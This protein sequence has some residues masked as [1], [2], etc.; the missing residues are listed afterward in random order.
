MKQLSFIIC[1]IILQGINSCFAQDSTAFKPSGKIIARSFI[2]YSTGF[3][4]VNHEKGFD[5]TRAFLGYN[6]KFTRTFSGQVIIDGASGKSSSN[7]IEVHLRNAFVNWSDK[8]FNI[9]VGLTGLMQF[10]IQENYFMHRYVLKSFQDLNKMAPS[11]DLGV[12]AE[13][14]FND[15]ISADVSITNGEGYK[16]IKKDNNMRYAAGISLHPIKNTILRVYADIYNDDE[17]G[18]DALPESATDAKYKDQY[19]LSL[20]A[21]YQD[22]NISGGV[23][24]NR[25]Y[26]KGFIEKKDYYGYSAYASGKVASKWRVFARYDLMDS[27][28]PD[29]FTSPW[30]SLDGQLMMI[31]VEFQP[32]KQLKIAPNFRNI[33]ADRS[34]SE[35]YAYIN[36]EFNL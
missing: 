36:I 24:Y 18:R 14:K 10:S 5:I 25:V 29:N 22:K 12:T 6:Y 1:I 7:D 31:G 16:K 8:G 13:Y 30:N 28:N 33:N 27:T 9:N 35:Q 32:L 11:V 3:G 26:N 23:E 4:H 15:Y 21:G 2:D 34:K 19:S 20:F 17:A